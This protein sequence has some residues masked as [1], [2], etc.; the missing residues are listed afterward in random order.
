MGKPDLKGRNYLIYLFMN[1]SPALYVDLVPLNQL[2]ATTHLDTQSAPFRLDV[3]GKDLPKNFLG[4]AFEIFIMRDVPISNVGAVTSMQNVQNL[5]Q[6]WTYQKFEL[7]ADLNNP[8]KVLSL[9]TFK[10]NPARVV[11]GLTFKQ[12]SAITFQDGK[13]VSFY[14][15]LPKSE[16]NQDLLFHFDRKV[17]SVFDGGRKDLSALSW[18]D[19]KFDLASLLN[20]QAVQP[21]KGDDAKIAAPA[22]D[23]QF[24]A[25]VFDASVVVEQV[26]PGGAGAA[27]GM[28]AGVTGHDLA[29]NL[30][31]SALI[32]SYSLIL[33]VLC[34]VLF[35][36]IALFFQQKMPNILSLIKSRTKKD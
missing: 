29:V 8:E 24:A 25:P 4:T 9:A 2:G 19:G 18:Q 17:L 16:L 20:I 28:S 30:F 15:S 35:A 34:I 33:T 26:G 11:F 6:D 14:L 12:G 10:T 13:I 31:D 22:G 21:K 23:D 32:P 36:L 5:L 27:D 7:S 1:T 3:M